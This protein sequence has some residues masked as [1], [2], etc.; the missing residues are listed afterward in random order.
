[1]LQK[2]WLFYTA[3]AQVAHT[4]TSTAAKSSWC[5]AFGKRRDAQR[6]K[7]CGILNLAI[8]QSIMCYR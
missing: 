8:M 1:M 7:E 4:S 5:S 6:T 2:N 3:C